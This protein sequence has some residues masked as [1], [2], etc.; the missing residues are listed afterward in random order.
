MENQKSQKLKAFT[1]LCDNRLGVVSTVSYKTHEPEAAL[2]YYV[3]D[4]KSIYFITPRQSRKLANL[5]QDNNIAFT[6]FTEIDPVELQIK[7]KV[8]SIDDPDKKSYITK[9]Y[10]ENA[11]K[12]PDTINWPPI[13]K[14]PNDEG[15][16]FVK[17]TVN[18]FKFSDFSER[19]GNIVEG[20]PADWE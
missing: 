10:L 2:V 19:E 14:V 13:L 3:V 18:W 12:N 4:Q 1:F 6:V 20:T 16:I 7:G 11:N 5:N 9:I 8:E 15:F 17:V